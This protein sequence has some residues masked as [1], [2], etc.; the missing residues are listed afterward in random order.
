MYF[1]NI[2]IRRLLTIV[3]IIAS[4]LPLSIFT[5]IAFVESKQIL[6]SEISLDIQVKA[7]TIMAEIDRMMFERSRNIHSWSQLEIMHELRLGDIDKRLSRFLSDLK[8]SYRGVY[9]EIDAVNLQHQIIASSDVARLGK[10]FPSLSLQQQLAQQQYVFSAD[11][12]DPIT[13][14]LSGHLYAVFDWQ[15]IV[16]LLDRSTQNNRSA[17]LF[18]EQN[19]LIAASNHW[20]IYQQTDAISAQSLSTSVLRE[21]P[22]Q[23]KVAVTQPKSNAF[24]SIRKLGSIFLWFLAL[25]IVIVVLSAF[26]LANNLSKPIRK[27]Y[28]FTRHFNLSK[29]YKKLEPTG[30]MELKQLAE[31]F[32]QM[33]LDLQQSQDNLTKAAKLA[34]VGELASAMSHEV[35][36][37]LGILRSSAQILMR[38]KNLSDEAKEVC[39]FILSETER[40]NKLI[41]TLLDAGR[42]RPQEIARHDL[43]ALCKKIIA[44]LQ[45]KNHQADIQLLSQQPV[46]A[47]IDAEQI[48]QVI[49]NL[50]INA[51]QVMTS[52]GKIYIR[53][54]SGQQYANIEIG[55]NG[56]GIPEA[57]R[58][59]IFD[60]FF[61]QRKGGIGLG[62]AVVKK[63]IQAHQGTIQAGTSKYGGAL[64]TIQLPLEK[65]NDDQTE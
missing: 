10:T 15:Q 57:Y 40:M 60:P 7:N 4:V 25:L 6:E 37:P 62:L 38:E 3:L 20:N 1:N 24:E 61:S 44:M 23:W 17:A 22:F 9:V 54:T 41:D 2:S 50:L 27:L 53:I 45:T 64:F 35:R 65:S 59:Q 28:Q 49:L 39:G 63:I 51:I 55:D 12:V 36:T 34:V 14:Q 33:I 21:I 19:Q 11:I 30:P 13:K 46:F 31:A 43:L 58:E 5:S 47:Q 29:P 42:N 32:D 18:N 56:P 52:D 16:N 26:A 8:N 48:T